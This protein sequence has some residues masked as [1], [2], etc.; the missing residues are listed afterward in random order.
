MT[1]KP[2]EEL[3]SIY[4]NHWPSLVQLLHRQAVE[5]KLSNPL[6]VDFE[7]HGYYEAPTKLVVVGQQTFGYCGTLGETLSGDPIACLLEEYR[8]FNL[9]HSYTKSPFWRGSHELCQKLNPDSG[10]PGF[11][12]TNLVKLDEDGKRP[13]IDVENALARVFDVLADEIR[14]AEPDVVVFFTGPNYDRRL[15]QSFPR[16]EFRPVAP[17]IGERDLAHLSYPGL[18]ALSFRTYHP[19]YLVR[20]KRWAHI[21]RIAALVQRG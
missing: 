11:L 14:L 18:P 20:S 7:A 9:G 10:A 5:R 15:V 12:W 6:L 17:G 16:C 13:S 8:Q 19:N 3:R 4:A 2:M 21:G 1:M